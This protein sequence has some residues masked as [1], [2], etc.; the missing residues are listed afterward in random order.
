MDRWAMIVVAAG[1]LVLAL[2]GTAVAGAGSA[3]TSV[4]ITKVSKRA[5]K[6]LGK[7]NAAIRI[8]RNTSKQQGPKGDAGPKGDTGPQGPAGVS[9]LE[10]VEAATPESSSDTKEAEVSCPP[11][12]RVFGGGARVEGP[13]FDSVALDL[14]GPASDTGWEAGAHEHTATGGAWELVVYAICGNAS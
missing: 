5:S 6:A 2:V 8:A 4:S 9:G 13:A 3:T 7:A 12:K 14:N 1:I 10:I 11:G